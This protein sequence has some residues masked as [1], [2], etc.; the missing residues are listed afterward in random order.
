MVGKPDAFHEAWDQLAW[1]Q[2]FAVAKDIPAILLE[3]LTE[4]TDDLGALA[5]IFWRI[6]SPG[7]RNENLRFAFG[8]FWSGCD[9]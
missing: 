7:K 9:L 4:P 1:A 6:I 3:R 2:H 5:G 8:D